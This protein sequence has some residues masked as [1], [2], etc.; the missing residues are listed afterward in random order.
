MERRWRKRQVWHLAV[1]KHSVVQHAR[2]RIY[3]D[4]A[5]P[6]WAKP[7]TNSLKAASRG[8]ELVGLSFSVQEGGI[9]ETLQLGEEATLTLRDGN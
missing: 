8:R 9:G 1:R 3:T 7:Q 6:P 5:V 2:W 4:H